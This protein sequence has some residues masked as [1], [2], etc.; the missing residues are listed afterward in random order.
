MGQKLSIHRDAVSPSIIALVSFLVLLAAL[1]LVWPVWRAF[2]PLEIL[3]SE[4]FDAYHAD[5]ALS[6]PAHLYPPP[7]GLIAN[8]YPP[9]YY[10]LTGGLAQLF[11]DAVYV[12]RA[13]SLLATVGLGIAAALIVR[14]F[15]GGKTAAFLA[16]GWYVATMARLYD[17]YVG[18]NDPQLFAHLIMAVALLW[19]ISR[20]KAGR[21]VEPA[22]LVMVFA[23]FFKHNVAAIPIAALIWLAL[24]D[25]RK[26]LRAA[27]FGAVAMAAGLATCAWLWNPYFIGDLL[28]PRTYRI[29]RALSFLRSANRWLFA[30][31]LWLAWALPERQSQAARFTVLHVSASFALFLLQRSL[32]GVGSNGQF[33]LVFALAI[34]I[35][36]AFD[37]LPFYVARMGWEPGRIRLVALAV[38]LAGLIASPRL[39]FAYVL[40]S[41]DYRALA[42][43]YAA[44]ARAEAARLAAVPHPIWSWNLVITRMARK[45]F[46]YDNFKVSQMVATGGY[47]WDEIVAKMRA[48]S[49]SFEPVDG[50]TRADSLLRRCPTLRWSLRSKFELSFTLECKWGE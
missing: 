46:V 15:G 10:F 9:L 11:G 14:V 36:L 8:N 47:S 27:L 17:E 48:Q 35:G 38:L 29:D 32:P 43:N 1:F 5:T 39:E 19:F 31:V 18:A 42:A 44:I 6:A 30:L 33:D 24:A 3:R 2:L 23:E 21:S 22:V 41:S 16:A 40:F 13:I 28:L 34:G 12:G 4:G 26:G 7:D 49:I 37:R 25:W 45:A 20:Y 50:R